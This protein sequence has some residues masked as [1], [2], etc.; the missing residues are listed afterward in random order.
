M[1]IAFVCL[2]I[3]L[4]VHCDVWFAVRGEVTS[5]GHTTMLRV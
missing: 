4:F 3:E 5:D 2:E 1:I